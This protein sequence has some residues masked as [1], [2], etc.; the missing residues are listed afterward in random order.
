M[1]GKQQRG[2]VRQRV[3]VS[4]LQLEHPVT[5]R[6]RPLAMAKVMAHA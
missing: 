6:G 4:A 5:L 1:A 3:S 2:S